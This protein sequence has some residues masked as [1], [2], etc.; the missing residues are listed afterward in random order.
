VAR[1]ITK[2]IH[3]TERLK[4]QSPIIDLSAERSALQRYHNPSAGMWL[5]LK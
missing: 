4:N 2:A 5:L 3:G 1:K